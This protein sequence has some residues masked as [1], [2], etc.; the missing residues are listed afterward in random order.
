MV[1]TSP[2]YAVRTL[3]DVAPFLV[4][5]DPGKVRVAFVVVDT[6][7]STDVSPTQQ[8]YLTLYL[9]GEAF[10]T[11]ATFDLGPIVSLSTAKRAT[12]GT[13]EA[14]VQSVDAQGVPKKATVTVDASDAIV[15]M[16]KIRCKDD[17]FDCTAAKTFEAKVDVSVR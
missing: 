6:G 8:L 13:Y 7:G 12:A 17:E 15:A 3:D 11:D 4:V 10:S 16:K 9:K 2:A 14:V 5:D 1:D